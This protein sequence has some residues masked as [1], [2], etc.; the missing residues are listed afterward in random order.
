MITVIRL[1]LCVTVYAPGLC[2][3]YSDSAGSDL[4]LLITRRISFQTWRLVCESAIV[5]LPTRMGN[6]WSSVDCCF[7]RGRNQY[8]SI[9]L[10]LT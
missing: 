10:H 3:C 1:V 5:T 6:K 8:W 9:A 2:T 7:K 4:K